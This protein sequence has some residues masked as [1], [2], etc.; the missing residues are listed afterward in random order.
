MKIKDIACEI[1]RRKMPDLENVRENCHNQVQQQSEL[2]AYRHHLSRLKQ[3][4]TVVVVAVLLLVSTTA[5]AAIGGF[6]WFTQRVNPRFGE[7]AEPIMLYAEDEGIRIT[8]LGAQKFDYKAVFYLSI[9]DVTG[10]NR[11]TDMH[12]VV[13]DIDDIDASIRMHRSNNLYFD[14]YSNT[15]YQEIIITVG[16]AFI[17]PFRVTIDSIFCGSYI[18]GHENIDVLMDEV[19]HGYWSFLVCTSDNAHKTVTLTESIQLDDYHVTEFVTLTPFGLHAMGSRLEPAAWA[20]DNFTRIDIIWSHADVYVETA[21][22]LM[23]ISDNIGEGGSD[24]KRFFM[25]WYAES[26]I[27]VFAVTAIIIG[28]IR[29]PISY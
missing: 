14:E 18:E 13:L 26:P 29:I 28:D 7:V 2:E 4:V 20:S 25:N 16:R 3:L 12:F 17:E 22:G 24:G 10:E 11:L 8:L 23:S 15:V 19:I 9:S 5:M 6:E 21:D 27:D 1:A